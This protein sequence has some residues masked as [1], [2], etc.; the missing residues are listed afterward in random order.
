MILLKNATVVN[1]DGMC[2]TD[3]MVLD[4]MTHKE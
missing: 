1:A 2:E 3:R 4:I